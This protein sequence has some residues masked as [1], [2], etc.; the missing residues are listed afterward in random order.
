MFGASPMGRRVAPRSWMELDSTS[1]ALADDQIIGCARVILALR[2]QCSEV[3]R[4]C[5]IITVEE[6]RVAESAQQVRQ[7]GLR[8]CTTKLA[9]L[10]P[11][12]AQKRAPWAGQIFCEPTAAA[13][14]PARRNLGPK[15]CSRR[16]NIRLGERRLVGPRAIVLGGRTAAEIPPARCETNIKA[17][18]RRHPKSAAGKC[19]SGGHAT[20][21][22]GSSN[23]HFKCSSGGQLSTGPIARTGRASH[24][25]AELIRVRR[26]SGQ[27]VCVRKYGGAAP[28]PA[29]SRRGMA[30]SAHRSGQHFGEGM[31]ESRST[32]VDLHPG[33][34]RAP[35]RRNNRNGRVYAE[36]GLRSTRRRC[37]NRIARSAPQWA[38]GGRARARR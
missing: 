14:R 16:A 32:F 5:W 18:Q 17:V 10:R 12:I 29:E 1:I 15:K 13:A 37:G 35:C 9:S 6:D 25:T 26:T 33:I 27:D 7:V 31:G 11:H 30:M 20:T 28:A 8:T 2:Q 34:C 19:S 22:R 4:R 21:S 38:D 36:C 3:F 23:R 24:R